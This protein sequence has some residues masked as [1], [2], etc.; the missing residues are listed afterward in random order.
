MPPVLFLLIALLGL[1]MPVIV[2][3]SQG[4]HIRIVRIVG[5]MLCFGETEL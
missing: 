4:I 5:I 1:I 2:L 3:L